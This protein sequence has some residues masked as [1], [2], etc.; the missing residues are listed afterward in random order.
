VLLCVDVNGIKGYSHFEHFY[1]RKKDALKEAGVDEVI[2]W[3]VNDGAVMSAWADDQGVRGS[4][5]KFMGDPSGSLTKAL[6]IEMTDDGPKSV[7]IIGRCKRHAIYVVD[8]EVKAFAL[9]EADGDPAGDDDP[10]KTM[11]E[12]MLAAI[13]EA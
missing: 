13:K 9:S 5:I 10:S 11:P 2:V 12:A 7:G 8:G 3:C 1:N 6:D 4:M